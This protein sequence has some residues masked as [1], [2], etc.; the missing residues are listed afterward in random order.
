MTSFREFFGFP[1]TQHDRIERLL[2]HVNSKLDRL[3]KTQMTIASDIKAR[4]ATLAAS[5]QANTDATAAF[6]GVVDGLKAELVTVQTALA[7]YKASHPDDADLA[8][9]VESLDAI[10]ANTDAD[11]LAEAAAAGTAA[12]PE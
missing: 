5:T 3:E 8:G 6:A 4:L 10:I 11:T 2:E 1:P 9:I 12:E 7:D